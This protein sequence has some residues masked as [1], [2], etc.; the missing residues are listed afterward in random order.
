MIIKNK[1][2]VLLSM[3]FVLTTG[4]SKK[5][6]A[7]VT[8]SKGQAVV[9]LGGIDANAATTMNAILAADKLLASPGFVVIGYKVS[10]LAS[11]KTG[12]TGETYFGPYEVKGAELTEQVKAI[13][14]KY[15]NAK[16]RVFFEDIKVM[17][18]GGVIKGCPL[19]LNC[20]AQ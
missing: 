18:G 20:K 17:G 3:V 14:K 7:Q 4:F 12:P 10:I 8:N 6:F 9:R 15:L 16:T 19:I 2:L 13:M 11:D 5:G 1:G